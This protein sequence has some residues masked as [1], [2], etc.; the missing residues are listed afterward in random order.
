MQILDPLMLKDLRRGETCLLLGNGPSLELVDFDRLKP[1][2]VVIGMHRTW[3]LVNPPFHV[4][5]RKSCYWGEIE[6]GAWRPEGIVITRTEQQLDKRPI[7]KMDVKV[8]RVRP[9]RG[10]KQPLSPLHVGSSAQF[11]G[12]FALEAAAYMGF[13][14]IGVIG[15]D[16]GNGSGHAF[17]EEGEHI[18]WDSTRQRQRSIMEQMAERL[19]GGPKVLNLAPD[20]ALTC[21]ERGELEGFYAQ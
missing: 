15:Y 7:R 9:L 8:V 12:Q 2:V 14:T 18:S 6:D 20:S 3:R 21:F 19:A 13:Y 5:L 1:N 4:I 11:C 17:P 10:R 16:M